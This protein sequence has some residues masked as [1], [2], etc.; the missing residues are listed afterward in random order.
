M[1]LET[2]LSHPP[3]M[4]EVVRRKRLGR[5][6]GAA[7]ALYL[8]VCLGLLYGGPLVSGPLQ[9]EHNGLWLG[10]RFFD[11]HKFQPVSD[12][13]LEQLAE[14]CRLCGLNSLFVH[15]GPLDAEGHIPSFEAASWRR[16]A[17][18]LPGVRW[19]AWL[20]GL[21]AAFEG[22]APDTVDLGDPQVRRGV[23]ETARQLRQ[24]G[25][26]GVHYDLEPIRDGDR[27]F[28]ALLDQTPRP[29]SVATPHLRPP[30]AP[31]LFPFERMWTAGYYRQVAA[32]CDQVVYM[33]YDSAQP[34]P[35]LYARW[36]RWQV[37]QLRGLVAG[38]LL[39]G[40][41]TYDEERSLVHDPGAETLAAGLWGVR[42]AGKVDGVALYAE[43]TTTAEEWDLIRDSLPPAAPREPTARSRE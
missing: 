42:A 11:D 41:P 18:A 25:F 4:L 29:I 7:L 8:G 37:R 34:S 9:A 16:A 19:Y 40:L 28:L 24:L 39:I 30:G 12:L 22:V 17:R 20:G 14:R 35:E 36:M 1:L 23:A 31:P 38:E 21:N 13:E 26:A 15:V 43:W 32:R 27:N 10:H 6:I 3:P 2:I 33:G 5:A